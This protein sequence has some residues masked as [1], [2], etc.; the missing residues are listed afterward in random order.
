[1]IGRLNQQMVRYHI[2][3]MEA[4]DDQADPCCSCFQ[5]TVVAYRRSMKTVS[6]SM[7]K[8]QDLPAWLSLQI[9]PT[10]VTSTA[11]SCGSKEGLKKLPQAGKDAADAAMTV[12]GPTPMQA[13]CLA[14]N[15][16]GMA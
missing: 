13:S 7:P 16:M 12:D 15:S 4:G 1:M 14:C 5:C 2:M 11:K 9:S 6:Q 3:R 8:K 10:M